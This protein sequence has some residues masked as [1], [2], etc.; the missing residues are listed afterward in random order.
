MVFKPGPARQVDPNLT[1]SKLKPDR[2][3]KKL[4]KFKNSANLKV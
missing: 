1:D 3:Y 2:V 4:K